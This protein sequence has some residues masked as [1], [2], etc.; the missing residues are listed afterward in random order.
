MSLTNFRSVTP[1]AK[2]RMPRTSDPNKARTETGSPV[3]Q[4][5]RGS[6]AFNPKSP[7]SPKPSH[8]H[9]GLKRMHSTRSQIAQK[10]SKRSSP[11]VG[12]RRDKRDSLSLVSAIEEYGDIDTDGLVPKISIVSGFISDHQPDAE[13]VCLND[14]IPQPTATRLVSPRSTDNGQMTDN[15]YCNDSGID[16]KRAKSTPQPI[17]DK[18]ANDFQPA[19]SPRRHTFQQS[20]TNSPDCSTYSLNLK[21][22]QIHHCNQ[23]NGN[24]PNDPHCN[25]QDLLQ[26]PPPNPHPRS[27]SCHSLPAST[28]SRAKKA[29]KSGQSHWSCPVKSKKRR[30]SFASAATVNSLVEWYYVNS[31]PS[32]GRYKAIRRRSHTIANTQF[33][34]G[35]SEE[36]D[37]DDDVDHNTIANATNQDQGDDHQ[38]LNDIDQRS[39]RHFKFN[40]TPTG[41]P[42]GRRKSM[43]SLNVPGRK[44]MRQTLAK[45]LSLDLP[46][47]NA[48]NPTFV[49]AQRRRS[50]SS[51]QKYNQ[52]S[53]G[54]IVCTVL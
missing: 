16:F 29:R 38:V 17:R 14:M 35:E 24:N 31:V 10:T 8:I 50:S 2:D 3:S 22:L 4:S 18:N 52:S 26:T 36:Y 32:R 15:E 48:Q 12:A 54:G 41:M 49:K 33:Q 21:P 23:Q 40:R 45:Q 9:P 27:L 30:V 20:D 11:G 46:T 53:C 1:T 51:K 25:Q 47:F 42:S 28:G 13:I 6:V 34:D 7:S 39:P 43:C 19:P 44:K 5:R 37:E